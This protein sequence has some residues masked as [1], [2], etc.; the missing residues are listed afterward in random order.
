MIL[1]I[2]AGILLAVFMLNL[3]RLLPIWSC[4]C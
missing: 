4:C 2:A 1:T 3:L